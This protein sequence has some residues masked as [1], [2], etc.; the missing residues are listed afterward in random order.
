MERLESAARG[1]TSRV[2]AG[3]LAADDAR[4]RESGTLDRARGLSFKR[5]TAGSG[6]T[7]EVLVTKVVC[8]FGW[9]AV[10]VSWARRDA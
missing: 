7:S 3:A 4:D 5:T 9:G 2:G 8:V 10:S 6:P 1:G